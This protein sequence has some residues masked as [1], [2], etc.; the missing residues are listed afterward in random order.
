MQHDKIVE[1]IKCMSQNDPLLFPLKD[2]KHLTGLA[3]SELRFRAFLPLMYVCSVMLE[4]FSAGWT[5]EA[6]DGWV[7]K[8]LMFRIPILCRQKYHSAVNIYLRIEDENLLCSKLEK[9]RTNWVNSTN[10]CWLSSITR[11]T[12]STKAQ[13]SK[14]NNN[15]NTST[16][17]ALISILSDSS[18]ALIEVLPFSLS[19]FSQL[20]ANNAVVGSVQSPMCKRNKRFCMIN[21]KKVDSNFNCVIRPPAVELAWDSK[22][23]IR[24]ADPVRSWPSSGSIRPPAVI[25]GHDAENSC[26]NSYS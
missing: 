2:A 10:C 23:E 8:Q 1:P 16:S 15:V 13:A 21:H 6:K 25:V 14:S 22:P 9:T 19:S 7:S 24:A 26:F 5:Y 20:H 17:E 11:S 3:E 4:I 18:H 12:V